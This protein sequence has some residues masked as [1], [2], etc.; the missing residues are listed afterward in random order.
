MLCGGISP[1][2]LAARHPAASR[3]GLTAHLSPVSWH[4][5]CRHCQLVS[6][7][8]GESGCGIP[9]AQE[10]RSQDRQRL[11]QQ[12]SKA[13]QVQGGWGASPAKSRVGTCRPTSPRGAEGTEAPRCA[14]DGCWF[15]FEQVGGLGRSTPGVG[16]LGG[17]HNPALGWVFPS[18]RCFSHPQTGPPPPSIEHSAQ[19]APGVPGRAL[20]SS[21]GTVRAGDQSCLLTANRQTPG[22]W[23]AERSCRAT[24][25][26][27]PFLHTCH[28]LGR[29]TAANQDSSPA[30]GGRDVLEPALA[31]SAAGSSSVLP[32]PQALGHNDRVFQHQVCGPTLPG[33][34]AHGKSLSPGWKAIPD[35]AACWYRSKALTWLQGS[36]WSQ[37]WRVRTQTRSLHPH[38]PR[39][40]PDEPIPPAVPRRGNI[41]TLRAFQRRGLN[42]SGPS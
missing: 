42:S 21:E 24:A 5:R 8:T 18:L 41:C 36:G 13:G 35:A 15:P 17:V 39:V 32:H 27:S 22:V 29:T 33:L 16:R 12:T 3:A 30:P 1:Q 4:R 38:T 28:P 10:S 6:H 14:P 20:R 25:P 34:P 23:Q 11:Q 7:S 37:D 2:C 26:H 19:T 40:C 31:A 9:G